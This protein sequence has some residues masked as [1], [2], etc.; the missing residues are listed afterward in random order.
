MKFEFD[1][2][3]SIGNLE[4]HGLSLD[5]AKA[6][7]NA[8]AV[9]LKARCVDE[10]RFMMIGKIKGKFY[11]CIFTLRMDVI[12]LISIRRSHEKEEKF[13]AQKIRVD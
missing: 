11:S 2:K 13:Y 6:L 12:R 4:K 5:D 8:P 1:F 7:W 9:V 3:K 10:E